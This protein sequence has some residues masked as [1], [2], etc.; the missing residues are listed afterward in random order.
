MTSAFVAAPTPGFSTAGVTSLTT[1]SFAVSGT[2]R[3]LIVGVLSGAGTPLNPSAVKWGGS[4]GTAMTQVGTTIDIG[5]NVKL[6]MWRLIAPTIQTSTAYVSWASGQDETAIVAAC[7]EGVD[8]TTPL[9]T[10]STATAVAPA[11]TT[12][13]SV[14]PVSV[15]GDI[16]VDV[17]GFLDGDGN[18]LTL[19]VGAGQTSHGEVEGANLSFEGLG[20][21]EKTATTTTTAMAW[22]ISGIP[23]TG[24]GTIAAALI[25]S[26][27]GGATFPPVPEPPFV[28]ANLNPILAR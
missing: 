18:A 11:S 14:S 6:S 9:R 3:L 22:T 17:A 24:W 20:T 10:A 13:V 25:A 1:G 26:V 7:Y 27:G 23:Q 15:A 5:S 8:Q 4:G 2:N 19:A 12:A 28:R 21:S 16:V